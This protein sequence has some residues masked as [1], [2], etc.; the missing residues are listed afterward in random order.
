MLF[1]SLIV[2]LIVSIFAGGCTN[3]SANDYSTLEVNGETILY[4][5]WTSEEIQ[6]NQVYGHEVHTVLGKYHHKDVGFNLKHDISF[7]V[8]A[9]MIQ[10]L[11]KICI[12]VI[13]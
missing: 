3:V 11:R 7:Y 9:G 4:P 5:N 10:H 6:N 8:L 13:N 2:I 12:V 1:L